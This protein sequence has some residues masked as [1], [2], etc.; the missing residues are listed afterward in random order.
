MAT[1]KAWVAKKIGNNLSDVR[2]TN[3]FYGTPV[4]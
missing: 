1:E 2:R 4:Y 3:E